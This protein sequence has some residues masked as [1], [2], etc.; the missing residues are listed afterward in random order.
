[1]R[2]ELAVDEGQDS[3][4]F[5]RAANDLLPLSEG[6]DGL[7]TASS[8]EMVV[9]VKLG[10]V[11]AA[12]DLLPLSE[13]EDG[14]STASSCEMVVAAKLGRVVTQQIHLELKTLRKAATAVVMIIRRY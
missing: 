8:C 11:R 4:T 9:A 3:A 14:L 12:N 13:G 6:E 7:S 10:R 1:F 5:V 2:V